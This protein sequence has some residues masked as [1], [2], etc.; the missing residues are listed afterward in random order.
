MVGVS[1]IAVVQT[2]RV[3]VSS[4]AV[5]DSLQE[6][7]RRAVVV[8]IRLGRARLDVCFI[9]KV[10]LLLQPSDADAIGDKIKPNRSCDR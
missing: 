8:R 4:V 3:S 2:Q 5:A 9:Q 10:P 7:K 6:L 1:S